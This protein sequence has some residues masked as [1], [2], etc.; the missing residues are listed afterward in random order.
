M[1]TSDSR[2]SQVVLSGFTFDECLECRLLTGLSFNQTAKFKV[3]DFRDTFTISRDHVHKRSISDILQDS[4]REMSQQQYHLRGGSFPEASSHRPPRLLIPAVPTSLPTS[5]PTSTTM[6]VPSS[7]ALT[8]TDASAPRNPVYRANRRVNAQINAVLSQQPHIH[9]GPAIGAFSPV[10]RDIMGRRLDPLLEPVPPSVLEGME[11]VRFCNKYHLK[12]YCSFL[13]CKH[14]H[15]IVDHRTGLLRDLDAVEL[16]ALRILAR[17]SPCKHG[18]ACND[19]ACYAGHWCTNH[20]VKP[21][22]RGCIF[23]KSMHYV[24][25]ATA[26]QMAMT[27]PR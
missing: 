7:G 20:T 26:P 24:R 5:L 16:R 3:A 21:G 1:I 23:P 15:K 27:R 11:G 10:Q 19:Q 2:C 18:I 13:K 25:T 6:T 14:R 9:R 4:V 12:R 22:D 8:P 17:R